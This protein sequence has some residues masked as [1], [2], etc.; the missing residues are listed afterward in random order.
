MKIFDAIKIW[1]QIRKTKNNI[2][3]ALKM[4]TKKWYQSKTVWFNI[5]SGVVAVST[6]LANSTFA[7]DPKVQAIAAA[8]ITLGNLALRFTT[9]QPITK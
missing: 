3:E 9:D 8:I 7:Q 1:M 5:I 6:T 2:E 4:E